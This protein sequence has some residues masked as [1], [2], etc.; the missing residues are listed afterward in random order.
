MAAR[1]LV[2]AVNVVYGVALLILGLIPS[3][4]STAASIPDHVA[5]AGAYA[6]QSVLL[7]LLFLSSGGRERAAVLAIA[8][9]VLYGGCVEMLQ[10]LQSARTVEVADLIANAVGATAASAFLYLA[11]GTQRTGIRR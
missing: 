1:R 3:V 2:I 11:T 7:Y 8:V 4:P 9:S 10:S 6:L 5:H